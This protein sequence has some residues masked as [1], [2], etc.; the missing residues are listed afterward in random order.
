VGLCA[1]NGAMVVFSGQPV[2]SMPTGYTCVVLPHPTDQTQVL[3]TIHFAGP[4]LGK[5]FVVAEFA[6]GDIFYYWLTATSTWQADHDYS[7]TDSVQPTVPNG[8]VYIISASELPQ[9]WQPNYAYKVG[10]VVVPTTLGAWKYTCIEA[11]GDNP[12]SGSTEPDWPTADGATV[13]EDI[14]QSTTPTAPPTV[15]PADPGGG[16]YGN[17]GGS[18]AIFNL[19]SDI[20]TGNVK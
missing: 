15:P 19:G 7:V 6:N 9:A 12:S 10:D 13:T 5:L 2:T 17:P 18:G 1:F 3:T 4:F 20:A 16:R 11:D 14:D 8:Y